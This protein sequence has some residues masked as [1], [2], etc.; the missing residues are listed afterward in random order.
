MIG[1]LGQALAFF[2]F[3]IANVKYGFNASGGGDQHLLLQCHRS[4]EN[5]VKGLYNAIIT[6]FQ[7][8]IKELA[9]ILEAV[10]KTKIGAKL[11]R[12]PTTTRS[13]ACAR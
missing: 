13:K 8:I 7:L 12:S 4:L 3:L 6:P 10:G 5:V 11:G 1:W 2:V 9:D